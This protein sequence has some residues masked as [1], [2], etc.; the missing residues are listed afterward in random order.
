MKKE[1]LMTGSLLLFAA[2][3]G[4]AN[5]VEPITGIDDVARVTITPTETKALTPTPAKTETPAKVAPK[6][7]IAKPTV[8][9]PPT[10]TPTPNPD[11]CLSGSIG[12]GPAD[13]H[14]LWEDGWSSNRLDEE[15]YGWLRG[16]F[17]GANVGNGIIQVLVDSTDDKKENAQCYSIVPGNQSVEFYYTKYFKSDGSVKNPETGGQSFFVSGLQEIKTAI[18]KTFKKGDRFVISRKASAS[19]YTYIITIN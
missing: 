14:L 11:T 3:C 4:A 6:T 16:K 19:G 8:I 13:L 17:G 2:G 10:R 5:S 1:F 18:E 12:P 7:P 9:R 15:G